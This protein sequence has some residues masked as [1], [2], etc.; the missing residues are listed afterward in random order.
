[1]E[2]P[3]RDKASY[4]AASRE[5]R[6]QFVSDASCDAEAIYGYRR[7]AHAEDLRALKNMRNLPSTT[8]A[9]R[10]KRK[11]EFYRKL[12]QVAERLPHIL[13]NFVG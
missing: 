8:R 2:K 3:W 11:A 1:M 6:R 10:F 7:R 9:Q 5:V 13:S 12:A 4:I